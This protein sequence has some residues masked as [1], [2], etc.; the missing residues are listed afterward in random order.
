MPQGRLILML[1][2]Q[3][4]GFQFNSKPQPPLQTEKP[5][6][7][8]RGKIFNDLVSKALGACLDMEAFVFL[9]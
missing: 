4:P 5:W 1:L 8:S 9:H 3:I 2:Q 7:L 6:A